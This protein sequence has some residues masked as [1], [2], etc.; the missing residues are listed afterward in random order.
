MLVILVLILKL[1]CDSDRLIPR[2]WLFILKHAARGR[3]LEDLPLLLNWILF[4]CSAFCS[5]RKKNY[6]NDTK[7]WYSQKK[8][9]CFSVSNR[10][11]GY[12]TSLKQLPWGY[13][14][15]SEP[16]VKS[17]EAFYHLGQKTLIRVVCVKHIAKN[18][19]NM[20]VRWAYIVFEELSRHW[21]LR[22]LCLKFNLSSTIWGLRS[23]YIMQCEFI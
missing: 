3:D 6:Y 9:A 10:F 21:S 18:S 11:M 12:L 20:V 4:P 2:I 23:I 13:T 1:K 5:K 22:L 15:G 16:R 7:V 14:L 19:E 8:L 17:A